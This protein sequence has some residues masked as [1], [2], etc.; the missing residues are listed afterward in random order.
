LAERQ[1][2]RLVAASQL[3]PSAG[4]VDVDAEQVGQHRGGHIAG[5]LEQRG[6]A[7]RGAVDATTARSA[8]ERQPPIGR[9]GEA[10]ET[11]QRS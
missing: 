1:V 7:I 2:A 8:A 5:K 6:A 9:P 11:S 10:P 3:G 4:A